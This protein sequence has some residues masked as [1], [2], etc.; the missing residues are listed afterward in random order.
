MRFA[1]AFSNSRR[2]FASI[3]WHIPQAATD[4]LSVRV[5]DVRRQQSGQ[6]AALLVSLILSRSG[7]KT[8]KVKIPLQ[9]EI[10]GARSEL[11]VEMAGPQYRLKDHRIPLQG[12]QKRGWGRV[13][14]PADVNP[15]NDEFYFV[16]DEAPPSKTVI[17]AEDPQAAWP[18]KLAAS[19]SPDRTA[20]CLAEIVPADQLGCGPLG[21]DVALAVAGAAS[22]RRGGQDGRSVR[23]AR[24][25]G[26]LPSATRPG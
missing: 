26:D 6:D 4:D 5:T 18:L 15:G 25:A 21:A 12:N 9:F 10:E 1:A 11:T 7:D 23:P 19:V 20:P 24:R 2:A 14:I 3:C 13:S 22:A 16:F 8:G 17:V